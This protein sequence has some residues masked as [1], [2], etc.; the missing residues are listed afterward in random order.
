MTFTETVESV[1]NA[2]RDLDAFSKSAI[3]SLKDKTI[4]LADRW[5]AYTQLVKANVFVHKDVC[6]DG[7]IETLDDNATLYDDFNVDRY[8]TATF[9]SMYERMMTADPKWDEQVCEYRDRNLEIWQEQ[10]LQSGYTSF[11]YDW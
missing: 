10:V 3:D 11:T 8:C 7:F 4:L 5:E 9:V 6:G 1:L 2:K